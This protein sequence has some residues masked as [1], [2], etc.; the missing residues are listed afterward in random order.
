MNV[1]RARTIAFRGR[2]E[3]HPST[4]ECVPTTHECVP[5]TH[6]RDPGTH[7]CD[8]CRALGKYVTDAIKLA[9]EKG[10]RVT[11]NCTLFNDAEPERVADFFDE[12]E[13]IGL[14][15]ITVSPGYA[16]E[17]AP[18]QEHFLNREK[19]KQLFRGVFERGDGAKKWPFAQS[20]LFLDFLAGNHT[21]S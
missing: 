1:I 17:R 11:I 7:E 2:N 20:A 13:K 16:Y 14:D 8:P 3:C 15:G 5:G 18:N 12:M 21:C 19:T 9:K 6:E 4:H 10:F